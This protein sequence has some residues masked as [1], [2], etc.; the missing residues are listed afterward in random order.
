MLRV[1]PVDSAML[2]W[3]DSRCFNERR[4]E[5]SRSLAAASVDTLVALFGDAK[6]KI[7]Q[8][9]TLITVQQENQYLYD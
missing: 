4:R 7:K 2:K 3:R 6:T 1:A 5:S 9:N 8:W